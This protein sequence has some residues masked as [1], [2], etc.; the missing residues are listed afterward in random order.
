MSRYTI[1]CLVC[2]AKLISVDPEEIVAFDRHHTER[3][4]DSTTRMK[5][6]SE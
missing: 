6:G 2:G 1:T 3:H 4:G 5:E